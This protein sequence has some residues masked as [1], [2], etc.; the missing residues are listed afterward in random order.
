MVDSESEKDERD[1]GDQG[2]YLHS[3][4]YLARLLMWLAIYKTIT[5]L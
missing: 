1:A 5:M 4:T 2:I 3:N